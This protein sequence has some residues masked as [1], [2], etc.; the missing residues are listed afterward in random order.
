M[1]G[2]VTSLHRE[3]H[4]PRFHLLLCGS[5]SG[6]DSDEI[7][8]LEKRYG[9]LL[10][11]RHLSRTGSDSAL[12]DPTGGALALLGVRDQAVYIIRPDGHVSYRSAAAS[13]DGAVAHLASL[14]TK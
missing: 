14:L 9:G 10:S 11:I 8:R 1:R 7:F 3:L 4:G 5:E 12:H 13:L 6:W 2:Q